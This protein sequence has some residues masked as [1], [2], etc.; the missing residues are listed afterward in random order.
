MVWMICEVVVIVMFWS[1][2]MLIRC[3]CSTDNF[4][5]LFVCGGQYVSL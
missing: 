4:S 3:A 2:D 5:D 1:V